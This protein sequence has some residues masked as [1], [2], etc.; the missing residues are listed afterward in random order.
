MK[1]PSEQP[2]EIRTHFK[3]LNSKNWMPTDLKKLDF[4]KG[5]KEKTTPTVPK[6]KGGYQVAK[7]KLTSAN[8]G[9]TRMVGKCPISYLIKCR[10][11]GSLL[12]KIAHLV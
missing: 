8:P 1:V 7:I 11:F 5:R 4:V 12:W 10:S 6:K 9:L 2:A 3:R